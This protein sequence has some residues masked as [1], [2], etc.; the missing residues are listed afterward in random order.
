MTPPKLPK[1]LIRRLASGLVS[2]FLREEQDHL[3][4]LVIRQR[5]R[6]AIDQLV[7]QP[8]PMSLRTAVGRELRRRS[9]RLGFVAGLGRQVHLFLDLAQRRGVGRPP[10]RR[11]DDERRLRRSFS[12]AS[13]AACAGSVRRPHEAEGVHPVLA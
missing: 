12:E 3:Q 5:R 10:V 11:L 2:P 8:R 9:A 4:R 13:A 6:A 1:R 7:A